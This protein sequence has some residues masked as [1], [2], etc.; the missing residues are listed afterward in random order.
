M[1]IVFAGACLFSEPP[2]TSTQMLWV[3]L[4]MDTFA[5]LALAT[6]PP[7]DSV[8]LRQPALKTDAIVNAIMWRNVIGQSI[9]QI[10]V[11]LVLLFCGGNM[12]NIDFEQS[13]DFYY[14]A[15]SAKTFCAETF[16]ATT[17]DPVCL[18]EEYSATPKVLMYTIVFQTFVFM[19]LFN[20]INSRK[21][22]ERDFNV[23]SL[24]FNNPMF[25]AITIFTFGV[26]IAIVQFGDRYM[27]CVP[28]SWE[29]NMICAGIGAFSLIWGLILKFVPAR[30]FEWIRL[31]ESE[32]TEEEEQ[33]GMLSSLKKSRTMRSA[34][35]RESKRDSTRKV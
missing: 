29:Q 19:Q 5:A 6:E 20:Q 13:D 30:W 25:I 33:S 4:I 34:S 31:E 23:F 22:G 24:F 17:E 12:F 2:L 10:I 28:L 27:R 3:N 16:V 14:T 35:Q 9:F 15:E 18:I 32:M 7:Q 1:F 26:Q 8:L 21:L 11:L